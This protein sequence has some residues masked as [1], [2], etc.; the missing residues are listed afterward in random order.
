[1]HIHIYI[2]SLPICK[3][4]PD[5]VLLILQCVLPSV[6]FL[7]MYL[8]I[9]INCHSSSLFL[10]GFQHGT[11]GTGEGAQK[12]NQDKK[13]RGQKGCIFAPKNHQS[14]RWVVAD[15]TKVMNYAQLYSSSVILTIIILK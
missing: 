8:G 9:E 4:T 12:K 10:G 3:S 14:S 1:M 2:K 15:R 11:V 5:S 7:K 6:L 13:E